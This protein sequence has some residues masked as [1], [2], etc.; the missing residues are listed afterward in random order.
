MIGL[1]STVMLLR[2]FL[3]ILDVVDSTLGGAAVTHGGR[4]LAWAVC[5]P[6]LIVQMVL[7]IH[8][9]RNGKLLF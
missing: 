9:I 1:F 7:L 4:V 3:A 5:M 2:I 8:G 6:V